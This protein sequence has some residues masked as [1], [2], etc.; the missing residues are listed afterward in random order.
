MIDFTILSRR[1]FLAAGTTVGGALAV[2][3]ALPGASL[4]AGIVTGGRNTDGAVFRPNAYIEIARNG[5]VTFTIGK[6]EMGQGTLT[7]IAQLLADELGCDWEQIDIVQAT[8]SPAYGFPSNGFMIT[9]GSS[10][11]RT[12]WTRMRTMAATARMMLQQAAAARW[13]VAP[14][15]LGV[16][17]GLIADGRGNK[18]GFAD[19]VQDASALDIPESPVLK[20]AA[21][22]RV[23]GKSVKR[24]DTLQKIT[25]KAQFGIDVD[26]PGMVTAI[27]ISPPQ[28]GAP[29]K[30]FNAERA[31]ARPG[32][33]A[34]VKI[35]TGIAI[36]G[37]HYWA[38]HSARDDVD[39]EWGDS[40]FAGVDMDTIRSGYRKAL[41]KPGKVARDTGDVTAVDRDR[42]IT[43]EF[44]QPYL[45]HAC[46]EPMN[47]TVWIKPDSAQAWGPTQAQSFVQGTVAK[48]AGIDPKKVTVHTTFLGGGFGRRSAQDFV[49]AA[50]E[51]AKST[52]RPVKLVYSR[53]D[54]MRAA[55]YRPFNL[56]R[57][58]AALDEKGNVSTLDV[59]IAIPSVS[60]WSGLKFLIDK[61]GIDK[62]AVEG[63][64][65]IAYDIPN[66]RVEWIDHDPMIPV[67]FWRA[68][69]S[70]HNPFVVESLIDDLA[71]AAGHDPIAFR[72][73]HLAAKPRHL[74][75]LDRLVLDSGWD[76]P[77]PTGIGRGMA[78]VE[79]FESIVAQAVE[80]RLDDGDLSVDKVACVIDCGV[81]V[82]PGLIE[83][84]MQGS[85]VYGL[86]AFLRNQVTLDGG[87]VDQSNFHDYEPLRMPEM[88]VIK[89]SIIEGGENPG[90]VG[91]PGL[92]PILPAV[93]NA[94]FALTGKRLTR[95]PY[96]L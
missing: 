25:G 30:S 58:T 7:G 40:P 29:V 9:G 2:A 21:D 59:K 43:H 1:G 3:A 77:A 67:H 18:I 57:A 20:P 93:A 75:V 72:R 96:E 80:I 63:L 38:V 27:V 71:H 36:V 6:S 69:G 83:A 32:V 12:E 5:R 11:L 45:A 44:E 47:F 8:S 51:I 24:V 68:V 22:R 55:R 48:V 39:V 56:T 34:V 50:A 42:A 84:Q 31:L 95:L 16:A 10:G 65:N 60:K 41:D 26:L 76:R 78:I 13:K 28:L 14:E 64:V 17:N 79:S 19:L 46:M 53:E 82:N 49:Q 74:A 54:D 81:A 87:V 52:D 23:I 73:S 33:V 91:E 92:P 90:G 89:V 61:N 4:A 85:I 62:Q 15:S 88:P 86:S 70:S 37:D 66:V 35:S 94:V